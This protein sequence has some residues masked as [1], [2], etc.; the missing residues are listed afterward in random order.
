[1]AELCSLENAFPNI[2]ESGT[3]FVGGTD[4][5]PTKEERRAAKKKAKR[6]KGDVD[7][8][9][10]SEGFQLPKAIP[11][12]TALVG[13]GYPNYFGKGVDDEEG[14]TSYAGAT[15]ESSYRLQ[16]DV[17]ATFDTKGVE[18]AMGSLLPDPNLSDRWKPMTEGGYTA[19]A[20]AI[21][22]RPGW[23]RDTGEEPKGVSGPLPKRSQ[24][25][26]VSKSNEDIVG[27]MN[28]LVGRLDQM[29][30]R[31]IQN[32]QTEILLFVG[33]GIMLLFTFEL[34]RR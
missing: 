25:S 7:P 12:S 6:C 18:K 11:K 20:S 30:K 21:A 1:M 9:R 22:A 19:F 24:E 13:S 28:E 5:K 15:D 3:P 16:P 27:R 33:A 14:F 4:E 26:W 34:V 23:A 32:T 8:D 17:T 29:E 31:R 2:K 10:P